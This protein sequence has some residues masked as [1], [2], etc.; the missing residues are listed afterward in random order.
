MPADAP[1]PAPGRPLLR[2]ALER[3]RPDVVLVLLGVNDLYYERTDPPSTAVVERTVARLATVAAEARAAG[4]TVLLATALP[5]RR[6]PPSRVAALNAAI[7]ALA[8]DF[9]PT[10]E[11]F[12][13]GDWEGSLAD[14]VH[15]NGDGYQRIADVLADELV[16]RGLVR[17]SSAD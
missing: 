12:A 14:D 5:N 4:A 13:E 11:R 16:R 9:V 7:R 17:R 1:L 3:D 6:D 2:A 10:G 8:P 15:P